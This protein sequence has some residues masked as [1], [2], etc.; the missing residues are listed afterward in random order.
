MF[1]LTQILVELILKLILINLKIQKIIILNFKIAFPAFLE[2]IRYNIETCGNNQ[3]GLSSVCHLYMV[4]VIE[5]V[6][7]PLL[8]IIT[9][10]DN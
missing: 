6:T 2:K 7:V 10:L 1:S 4:L 3:L 5:F 9:Y 8:K